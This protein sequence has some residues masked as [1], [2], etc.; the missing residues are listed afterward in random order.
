MAGGPEGLCPPGPLGFSALCLLRQRLAGRS[1][2]RPPELPFARLRSALGSLP[3]VALSSAGAKRDDF[4]LAF[5]S[6]FPVSVSRRVYRAGKGNGRCFRGGFELV[7]L[8]GMGE[9]SLLLELVQTLAHSGHAHAAE[10]AQALHG[11]R[12][13]GL[14]ERL[15]NPF[16][17]LCSRLG[18]GCR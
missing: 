7:A 6:V 14:G 3:S 1:C 15:A 8:G 2:E 4:Q 17:R 12:C 9:A 5:W 11:Q 18:S 13:V 10:L 16:Q